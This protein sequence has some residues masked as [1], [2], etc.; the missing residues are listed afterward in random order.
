[1]SSGAQVIRKVD[2]IYCEYRTLGKIY[3]NVPMKHVHG[4]SS[5]KLLTANIE[6]EKTLTVSIDINDICRSTSI[7]DWKPKDQ[8]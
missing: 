3:V 1:M 6:S 5:L 4:H 7:N 8:K 2:G